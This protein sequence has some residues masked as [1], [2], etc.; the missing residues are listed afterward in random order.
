MDVRNGATAWKL[1]VGNIVRMT[2]ALADGLL[3]VATYGHRGSKTVAPTGASTERRC[4]RSTARMASTP[5][6]PALGPYPVKYISF[7]GKARGMF[8]YLAAASMSG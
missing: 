5:R 1:N 8:L 3:F 2:P 4:G 7:A 6:D